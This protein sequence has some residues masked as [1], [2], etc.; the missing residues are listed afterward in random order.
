[1]K[2]EQKLAGMMSD[3]GTQLKQAEETQVKIISIS[4][5]H[6]HQHQHQHQHQHHKQH[7]LSKQDRENEDELENFLQ[8]ID[9]KIFFSVAIETKEATSRRKESPKVKIEWNFFTC[10]F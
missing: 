1:M 6:K 7:H 2:L 9:E 5:S 10:S 3:L 4:I 8:N